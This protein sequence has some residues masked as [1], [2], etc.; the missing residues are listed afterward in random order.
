M[1]EDVQ[2][3]DLVVGDYGVKPPH[4]RV[5]V[6]VTDASGAQI[7]SKLQAG[8]GPQSTF[9][10]GFLYGVDGDALCVWKC[11]GKFAHTATLDG[12]IKTCFVNSGTRSLVLF[13][14]KLYGAMRLY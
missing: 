13:V 1:S 12:E 8:E 4:L 5:Q 6:T 2:K 3:G 11:T 10:F 14:E 7:Y 9:A